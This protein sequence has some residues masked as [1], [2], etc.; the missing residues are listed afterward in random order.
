[1]LRLSQLLFIILVS[2]LN[3]NL[4]SD[5]V[6]YPSS[7]IYENKNNVVIKLTKSNY[8]KFINYLGYSIDYK[9]Y[10]EDK[11]Y[12]SLIDLNELSVLISSSLPY[13]QIDQA[14]FKYYDYDYKERIEIGYKNLDSILKGYKDNLLN[15]IYLKG[16]A[17]E[18]PNKVELRIIGKSRL[19]RNIYALK[20]KSN[21]EKEVNSSYLFVGAHHANELISTEHCYDVIYQLLKYP[22]KYGKYLENLSIWVVPLLNPDGSHFFWNKTINMGRKNGF[23]ASGMSEENIFRGVDLNRN[24]PFKWKSGHP[25][26]SSSDPKNSFYRGLSPASEPEVKAMIELAKREHF[27]FSYSFHSFATAVLF[28]YTIEDLT[29]PNPDYVKFFGEKIVESSK[30]YRIDKSFTLKKNLYPVDG[31]D[32]DYY[33]HEFGTNAFIIESSHQNSEYK[34]IL[35]V[36]KGFRK[37]WIIAL[38][39][40]YEGHKI[41]LKVQNKDKEPLK[42]KTSIEE[43]EYSEKEVHTSNPL[44][45]LFIKLFTEPME[46]NIKIESESYKTKKIRL[47]TI[48][49]LNPKVITL[50]EDD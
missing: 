4:F 47:N 30:S 10:L 48:N 18:F 49:S 19:G 12:I 37:G 22:N 23:L 3:C 6:K 27:L 44:N 45:G 20:I 42:A 34:I 39:E 36:L 38:N 11:N 7:A 21:S 9:T 26:A 35:K 28:P 33:Y 25:K 32:Q 1:L 46:L 15:E 31:T 24:Y 2:F 14:G 13:Q 43:I 41:I 5:S 17:S 40:F 16:I 50:Q 8:D 29:N